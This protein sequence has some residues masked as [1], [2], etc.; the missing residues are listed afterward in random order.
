MFGWLIPYAVQA[1]LGALQAQQSARV[2]SPWARFESFA[3]SPWGMAALGWLVG[4]AF[5]NAFA[6]PGS[7]YERAMLGAMGSLLGENQAILRRVLGQLGRVPPVPSVAGVVE[8]GAQAGSERAA[9]RAVASLPV[10]VQLPGLRERV[11]SGA[12]A[13]LREPSLELLQREGVLP[14]EQALRQLQMLA[15]IAGQAGDLAQQYGYLAQLYGQRGNLFYGALPQLLA[16]LW[17][18]GL[19]RRRKG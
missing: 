2:A 13:A 10:G 9:E 3:Q 1:G 19:E 14:Y 11:R 12:Y 7:G 6:A 15:G 16:G 5:P 18:W 4:R 8:A 17:E